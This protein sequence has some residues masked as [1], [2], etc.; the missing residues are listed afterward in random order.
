MI[1]D[2]YLCIDVGTGSVRSALVDAQGHILF[3]ASREHE[4]I[5]PAYGWSEQRPADW[6]TGVA[7]TIRQIFDTHG[8][9]RARIVAVCACGQ[10]HGT[11][12][13]GADGNPTRETAPLW[14]D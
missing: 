2:L 5:V 10:M 1:R 6:W 13:I 4:Q 12:L 11:V 3:I 8:D 14:N 7:H 9:A